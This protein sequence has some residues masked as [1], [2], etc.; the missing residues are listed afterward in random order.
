MSHVNRS[1]GCVGGIP[2][3][4]VLTLAIAGLALTFC[5]RPTAAWSETLV[6]DVTL[7]HDG[8]IRYF[9]YYV[10]DGLTDSPVPLLFVLH[11]G[12]SDNGF[13]RRSA[14]G[15]FMRLADQELFIVLYPNGTTLAGTTGPF[16]GFGWNVCRINTRNPPGRTADDVGFVSALIDWAAASDNIDPERIYATG[17]SSGGGMSDRLAFELSDRIAAV[18]VVNASLPV[19]SECLDVPA[20]PL[21]VLI[22]NGTAQPGLPWEGGPTGREQ[23]PIG[24]PILSAHETRDFWRT[25]L[26]T[27]ET[28]THVD[29][30]DINPNDDSTVE[31]D[32]YS[33]GAEG[34]EVAFYT[35]NGGGHRFPSIAHD[36]LLSNGPQ[37]RD[38]EYTAEIWNFLKRHRLSGFLQLEIDIKPGSD[39]NRI[40]PMNRGIIPAALLGSDTFDVLDVDVTTLSFGRDGAQSVLPL[41]NPWVFHFFSHFDVN[42]DGHKD[43]FALYRTQETGIALTDDQA[44]LNG[45]TL[46]GTRFQG[47]DHITTV[48]KGCGLGFELVLLLPPLMWL[49]S[50]RPSS[51]RRWRLSSVP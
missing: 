3:R 10:P 40:N 26:G 29:V 24:A 43:L 27:D 16:G 5:L 15:E 1:L 25:F 7:V 23:P 30:P 51:R 12:G 14:A 31:I 32:V 42:H 2:T 50:R 4:I 48:P 18:G 21:A 41:T 44:C 6:E 19:H 35:V 38:I 46:D 13:V 11:P 9:D 39:L 37:N 49:R 28:P 33:N 20:N 45:E 47:C 22:M 8:L 34:S 17:G 36:D